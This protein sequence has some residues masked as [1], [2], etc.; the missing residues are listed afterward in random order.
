[1]EPHVKSAKARKLFNAGVRGNVRTTKSADPSCYDVSSSMEDDMNY[2][3]AIKMEAKRGYAGN[4]EMER[5][6]SYVAMDTDTMAIARKY[7]KS[8]YDVATD[9]VAV[10]LS[11]D[12]SDF[13]MGQVRAAL[14]AKKHR[15]ARDGN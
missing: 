6:P 10:R 11:N 1:M 14:E 12:R 7:S 13:A 4:R 9:I 3:D 15:T 5:H 8:P 2:R